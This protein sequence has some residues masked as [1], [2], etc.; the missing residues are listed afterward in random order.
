MQKRLRTGSF[1]PQRCHAVQVLWLSFVM[2]PLYALN[3]Q[4]V[5]TSFKAIDASDS[6]S[7]HV[8]GAYYGLA[9]SLMISRCAGIAGCARRIVDMSIYGASLDVDVEGAAGS[10]SRR[11]KW[12]R[13]SGAVNSDDGNCRP[14][15]IVSAGWQEA[16]TYC[17]VNAEIRSSA[18]QFTRRTPGATPGAH[19]IFAAALA[20]KSSHTH[21][22]GLTS[23]PLSRSN[24]FS[25]IATLLLWLCWYAAVPLRTPYIGT[26]HRPAAT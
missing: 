8:F 26:W 11:S 9:A 15:V 1:C 5:Y 4:I 7:I 23:I 22:V 17:R 3:Q 24:V 13:F 25:K 10:L 6:I 14:P 19:K 21:R 16:T 20:V 2:V 12:Q 18:H